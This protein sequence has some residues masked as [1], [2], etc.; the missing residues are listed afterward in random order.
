MAIFQNNMKRFLK[1]KMALVLL[2]VVPLIFIFVSFLGTGTQKANVAIIDHDRTPL[3]EQIIKTLKGQ[4]N[5]V[6]VTEKNKKGRLINGDVDDVFVFDKGFT[7]AMIAGRPIKLRSYHVKESN[8]SSG[9][10]TYIAGYLQNIELMAKLAHGKKN[11]FYQAYDHYQKNHPDLNV[12]SD[13]RRGRQEGTLS[14]LGF[15]I[16]GL[17]MIVIV[18][19]GLIM[20]D[21]EKNLYHRFFTTPL[22][23]KSY[24]LQNILS[25]FLLANVTVAALL[26]LLKFGFHA[27][28]GPSP[29][30]VYLVLI[31]F[32]IVA[33]AI[34]V[35]VSSFAKTAR[36]A[37]GISVLITT[38]VAMLGGCFWPVA[39]MPSYMQKLSAFTPTAWGVK[40]LTKLVYG[41]GLSDVIMDLIILALFAI[42]FF[43]LAS[44]RRT[45][46]AHE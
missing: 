34:G 23:L 16:Y 8:V 37:N 41:N 39:I 40:A 31:M 12:E 4:A 1:N 29:F 22:S 26:L 44:W 28:L 42:V 13:G 10:R 18:S 30:A 14:A 38:P 25:Y 43:L 32:S 5:V 3:T 6:K 19:S 24:N 33:I 2:L 27:M 7:A 17:F 11:T 46:I 15:I 20:E 21:K 9:L 36:Q 45:D 35:A